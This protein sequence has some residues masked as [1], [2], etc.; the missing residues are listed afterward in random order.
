MERKHYTQDDLIKLH[1]AI[2]KLSLAWLL[3]DRQKEQAKNKLL[4]FLKP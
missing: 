3:T 4:K 1:E 2:I